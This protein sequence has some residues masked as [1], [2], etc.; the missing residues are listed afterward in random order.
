[1]TSGQPGGA[2]IR[3]AVLGAGMIGRKH[4]AQID[5]H[6]DFVLGGIAEVN[7]DAAKASFPQV[8]VMADAAALL[9]ASKPDAVIVASP[10][11]LHLAHALM[12]VERGLP[13]IL[14]KPVTDNVAS[15]VTLCDAVRRAGL[16][17]LVGHHR[18]HHPPVGE[19]KRLLAEGAIGSVIGVSG[20]WATCKPDPYFEAGPWRK[21]KGG[22]PVLINLIHEIDFLRFTLGEI[23]T[24]SALTSNRQR[25]FEVEDTAAMTLG[26]ASGV[27]GTFLASD[28]AVSPW[29][30]EQGLGE[31]PDFPSPAKAAIAFSALWVRS[32]LRSCGFGGRRGTCEAGI[33]RCRRAVSM[34]G[35]PTPT[36]SSCRIS[37]TSSATARAPSSRWTM[38]RARS[39]RRSPCGRRPSRDKRSI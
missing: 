18:R 28:T 38:L 25:G 2:P 39:S 37:G 3:I 7:L 23:A 14:E 5:A 12:C 26:F 22:G 36:R 20:V 30:M 29:T 19:T 1:M 11:Q 24:V 21:Q 4:I 10:N 8:P 31:V 33:I 6:P 16:P 9:D 32:R 27:I 17:T 35:A 13:F 34:A 15:A